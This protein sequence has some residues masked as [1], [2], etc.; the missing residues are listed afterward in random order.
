[1]VRPTTEGSGW[2][3]AC[4]GGNCVEVAFQGGRVDVRDGKRGEGGPVLSFTQEEWRAF[5]Q[6]VKAGR[7][8]AP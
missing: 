8:D 5:V 4:N 6:G 3:S 1:M 2:I 7:F